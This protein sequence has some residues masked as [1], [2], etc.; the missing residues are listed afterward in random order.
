M[1]PATRSLPVHLNQRD[2]GVWIGSH[3]VRAES[4][5]VGELDGDALGPVDDVVVRQD[6]AV[7]V[8]DEPAAFAPTRRIEL[9][10]WPKVVRA[11]ELTRR[12]RRGTV[13][14]ASGIAS[15]GSGVDVHNGRIEAF[16]NVREIEKRR[17][18]R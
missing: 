15:R 14:S 18:H 11:V 2:V 13:S 9:K 4:P 8:D 1:R 10:P 3:N 17:G 12:L 6:A 7:G 16:H 5:P